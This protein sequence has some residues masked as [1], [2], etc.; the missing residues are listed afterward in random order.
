[1]P[2]LNSDTAE[3]PLLGLFSATRGGVSP[4]VP[5]KAFTHVLGLLL[6]LALLLDTQV[7]VV[8][9]NIY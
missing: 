2:E 7:A 6:D 8:A 3:V 9:Q 4:A 5:L 1:M